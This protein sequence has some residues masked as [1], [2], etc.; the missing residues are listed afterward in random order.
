MGRK[1][2]PTILEADAGV[3]SALGGVSAAGTPRLAFEAREYQREGLAELDQ[4]TEASDRLTRAAKDRERILPR[5]AG[6]RFNRATRARVPEFDE[7]RTPI[8]GRQMKVRSKL[9]R[10]VQTRMT[11]AQHR[12]LKQLMTDEPHFTRLTDQLSASV[13]DT[14]GFSD[15]DRTTVQR[16]DRAIRQYERQNE[17]QHHLYANVTLPPGTKL[18]DYEIPPTVHLDRW[19]GASHN[20]HEISGA[21]LNDETYALEITTRRG[22]YLGHS[23]SGPSTEHLLPRGMAFEVEK[24]YETRWKGPD[25]SSGTRRVIRLRE[26]ANKQDEEQS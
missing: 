12:E 1:Y 2:A 8:S 25:G 6:E 16:V 21:D 3:G 17:R 19:T 22:M 24:I 7:L 14:D 26:V 20:L 9:K 13:G 11:A 23:D 10:Q 4:L 5:D 15:R 18:S